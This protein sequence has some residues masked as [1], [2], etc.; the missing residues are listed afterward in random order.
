MQASV[1][2]ELPKTPTAP[3]ALQEAQPCRCR[4][5][6]VVLG[7][8]PE[9]D[10]ELLLCA[11]CKDR[12]EARRLN[13]GLVA[14]A[15]RRPHVAA[16]QAKTGPA[17]ARDFTDAERSLIK[18]MGAVLPREQLLEL[19]NERLTLDLGPD[20]PRYTIEMLERQVG[21]GAG[22]AASQAQTWS[23]LRKLIAQARQSGALRRVNEQL[24]HDFA[25]VYSISPK[26]LIT[27][28][29]I[30]L[31]DDEQTNDEGDA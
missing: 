26:Q 4:L 5:C 10:I 1:V 24:I 20:A 11:S 12:P 28:R 19:L 9:D 31:G 22:A 16:E 15:P 2:R 3:L 17:P 25:V 13:L 6:T 8:E 21:A 23:T 29:E 14:S 27:L 18:R 7:A 30:L